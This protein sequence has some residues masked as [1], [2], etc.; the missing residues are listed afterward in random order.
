[1]KPAI[2]V[3]LLTTLIGAGQGL[4][5]AYYSAEWLVMLKILQPAAGRLR[6][7]RRDAQF[8]ADGGGPAGF[9]LPSRSSRARL[10]RGGDVAHSWLSREVIA[11][12][13]AMVMILA[14]ALI[15]FFAIDL[16][17]LRA[18]KHPDSTVHA[19][20]FR[21]GAGGRRT[22][23]LHRHDIREPQIP[24]PVAQ[25]VD[26]AEFFADG[27]RLGIYAGDGAGGSRGAGQFGY[28]FAP[29]RLR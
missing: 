24:A 13:S 14:F 3:I 11:L 26:G 6:G 20:G 8:P 5:L 4:F 15:R 10:A 29:W 19:G 23:Y 7:S 17:S 18:R 22:V 16:R 12:P 25:P 27:L 28:F 2:S 1:M 9:I 21:R